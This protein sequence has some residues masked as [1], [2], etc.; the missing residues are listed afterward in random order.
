MQKSSICK[1]FTNAVLDPNPHSKN[2]KKT[3]ESF[4]IYWTRSLKAHYQHRSISSSGRC[5]SDNANC[6]SR[7][8]LDITFRNFIRGVSFSYFELL[9]A[10]VVAEL[11]TLPRY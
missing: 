8:L 3:R 4:R 2:T 11:W 6:C 10:K 7:Y 9:S 1:S 5:L